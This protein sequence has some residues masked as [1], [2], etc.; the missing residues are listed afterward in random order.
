MFANLKD[1]FAKVSRNVNLLKNQESA[2]GKQADTHTGAEILSRFQ[3]SWT[4][5]HQ[6]NEENA[7]EALKCA[8]HI[9]DIY[10]KLAKSKDNIEQITSIITAQCLR[11]NIDK[12]ASQVLVL[13]KSCE[14][15]EKELLN[16]ED[17]IELVNLEQMKAQQMVQLQGYKIKKI[18]SQIDL[19]NV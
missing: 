1:A 11:D 2:V 14:E 12:C 17:L 3:K 15:I 8:Q 16:F 18:G 6:F 9:N 13:C 5:I 10:K 19:F 7:N 4:E